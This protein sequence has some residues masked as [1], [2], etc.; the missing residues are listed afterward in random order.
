MTNIPNIDDIIL[1][2]KDIARRAGEKTEEI[3]EAGKLKINIL[4]LNA[5]LRK[6][7]TQIGEYVFECSAQKQEP[8]E[9]LEKYLLKPRI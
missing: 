5:E 4:T 8:G 9:I 3:A 7:Y 2:A 1:K 6:K